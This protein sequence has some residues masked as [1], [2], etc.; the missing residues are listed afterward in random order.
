MSPCPAGRW[1]WGRDLSSPCF[2]EDGEHALATTRHQP[3]PSAVPPGPSRATWPPGTCRA[4][5]AARRERWAAG[6][7][8]GQGEYPQSLHPHA[9]GS[10][11]RGI[12][13]R[14]DFLLLLVP[15]SS[16]PRLDVGSS[17]ETRSSPCCSLDPQNQLSWS[18]GR[19]CSAGVHQ[20]LARCSSLPQGF[21]GAD[22]T[23]G[24]PG[25][26]GNPGSPGQPVSGAVGSSHHPACPACSLS[27][28]LPTPLGA[29]GSS[30]AGRVTAVP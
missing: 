16:S 28:T 10:L 27:W 1:L 12:L 14:R 5:G 29:G 20:V 17:G 7:E 3:V 23:P 9:P 13:P 26:P 11:G 30:V 4:T 22:G 8:G 19:S 15:L 24:S 25:R 18:T 21:P 2:R 6:K